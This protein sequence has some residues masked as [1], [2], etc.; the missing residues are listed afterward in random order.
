ML[1]RYLSD[2]HLEFIYPQYLNKFFKKIP[3]PKENE[4]CVLAGDIG[5]PFTT[6]YDMFMKWI[7]KHF[8]KTFVIPGNHEYY[9]KNKTI[10]ETNQHMEEYF[11][12]YDNISLLNNQY[13]IYQDYCFIG[14]ILWSKIT[15]PAYKINDM[16]Q[17][18]DFDI[19]KYNAL[20][21]ECIGY[22]E[23]VIQ[24]KNNC[25]IITHHVPSD[26]L[27]DPK[28]KDKHM[29]PYNQWFC[30][31]M[32][33][34]IECNKSKIKLWFY[35]HTHTPCDKIIQGVQFLGNPIGYPQENANIDLAKCVDI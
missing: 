24:D 34:F 5:N 21:A 2:L 25:I 23:S 15:N 11:V 6:N 1:I 10:S 14:S 20:N 33:E 9:N 7:S 22:L 35:G 29:L 16:T 13:E 26:S 17:I 12:Q 4:I 30:C 19:P 32:D 28:Y 31:P 18:K 3:L 27:I 8:I